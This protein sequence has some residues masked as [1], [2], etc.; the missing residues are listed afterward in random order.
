M[1]KA[2]VVDDSR[3]IR[4]ILSRSLGELGFDI[5]QAGNGREALEAMARE[6]LSVGLALVDW[7]MPEMTGI[8]FVRRLRSD[9][10]Y[11]NVLLMMVT[12]ETETEQVAAALEAGANE[13]IMKPFTREAI[14]DK[15]RLLGAIQ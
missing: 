2:L 4:M 14:E 3:A 11:D 6:G 7:N 10:L 12:T 1:N 9:P 8:E 5:V 15:L 13:Y